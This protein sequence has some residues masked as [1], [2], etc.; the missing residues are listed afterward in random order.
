MAF[1][2]SASAVC[3]ATPSDGISDWWGAKQPLR[4]DGHVLIYTVAA[5]EVNSWSLQDEKRW[6]KEAA[7]STCS[8]VLF[9]LKKKISHFT[10]QIPKELPCVWITPPPKKTNFR[11]NLI[12]SLFA[13]SGRNRCFAE[14][15]SLVQNKTETS[16]KLKSTGPEHSWCI[17]RHSAETLQLF[18]TSQQVDAQNCK[19]AEL[20]L[21]VML[22]LPHV[23]KK[24]GRWHSRGAEPTL[25]F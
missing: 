20:H 2:W 24:K 21:P 16:E 23:L 22:H 9:I 18:V 14:P 12:S 4:F 7:K 3:S 1:C 25:K 6:N 19:K 17:F 5:A 13:A 11:T 10:F 15:C 8:H